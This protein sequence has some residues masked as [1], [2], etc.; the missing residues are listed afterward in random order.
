MTATGATLAMSDFEDPYLYPDT[1]LLRNL[2]DEHD[3][4]AANAK[5][6]D[7]SLLRRRELDLRPVN[8]GS[9]G[10][11]FD[12]RHLREIHRRLYQDVWA[13]AGKIRTVEISKGSSTFHPNAYIETAFANLHVWLVHD[14]ELLSNPKIDDDTF[15]KQAAELLEKV[16][17]LHPFRE[18][19]GR[20]QR[21]YLDQVAGIS[22]RKLSWRNID[23]RQNLRA[24]IAAFDQGSGEPFEALLRDALRPPMDGL[25]LLGPEAY[26]ASASAGHM[27]QPSESAPGKGLSPE[28]LAI[29]R[30]RFPELLEEQQRENSAT[31]PDY[32]EFD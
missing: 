27:L 15:V 25:E 3:P 22:G 8:P 5:E 12:L 7:F 28:Q 19:N 1:N 26:I 9:N 31:D 30:R 11:G 2:S 14:T 17:Y 32:F 4:V 23:S 16:N 21:A 6:R 18:G 20:T 10:T 13:W 29:R 24:S